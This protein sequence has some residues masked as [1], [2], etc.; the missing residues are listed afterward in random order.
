MKHKTRKIL[1]ILLALVMVLGLV[2]AFGT[3]AWA[4]TVLIGDVN[5]DGTVDKADSMTLSR[6]IANWTGYESKVD[7][8]AADVNR[9]GT[10]DKADSMLLSRYVAGWNV[11]SQIGQTVEIG[12]PEEL[13]V[14]IDEENNK[15]I[16]G[17]CTLVVEVSGGTAP[18]TFKWYRDLSVVAGATTNVCVADRAGYYRCSVRDAND[19][20]AETPYINVRPEKEL[21]VVVGPGYTKITSIDESATLFANADGGTAP[22]EYTWYRFSIGGGSERLYGESGASVVVTEP[23]SYYC[24][25]NDSAY[26]EKSSETV[27]VEADELVFTTQPQDG[28]ID[29]DNSNSKLTLTTKVEGGVKPYTYKWYK[30][31]SSEVLSTDPSYNA[32]KTGSYYCRVRDAVGHG[33]T[34]RYAAVEYSLSILTQPKSGEI[35]SNGKYRLNILA[36]GGKAPYKYRW[37]RN[38][39]LYAETDGIY[40]TSEAG[41]YY[42]KVTDA[43]GYIAQTDTV[44]VT[45]KVVVVPDLEIVTQPKNGTMSQDGTYRPSM[46]VTGGKA[47]YKYTYY[48]NGTAVYSDE[49]YSYKALDKTGN[50]YIVVKDS[51]GR[52]KKTN[53]FEVSPQFT[54]TE[55]PPEYLE[56]PESSDEYISFDFKA[57]GGKAPYKYSY[58][59]PNGEIKETGNGGTSPSVRIL[60]GHAQVGTYVGIVQDA[61]KT[62]RFTY[63]WVY[64]RLKPS[65]SENIVVDPD[66][67]DKDVTVRGYKSGGA[68]RVNCRWYKWDHWDSTWRFFSTGETLTVNAR[69]QPGKYR[70]ELKDAVGTYYSGTFNI[71]ERRHWIYGAKSSHGK[72][73]DI[74]VIYRGGDRTAPIKIKFVVV[75]FSKSDK[76]WYAHRYENTDNK[77]TYTYN[78][79]G[80][81]TF[82]LRNVALVSDKPGRN[83]DTY[84]REDYTIFFTHDGDDKYMEREICFSDVRNFEVENF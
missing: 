28:Y 5:G 66:S 19:N 50:W 64:K 2:P 74:K 27:K 56:I 12:E 79:D 63:T 23:G 59:C 13:T 37:Y 47:P 70:A 57:S 55:Q 6:Y 29:R 17:K 62:T 42:C 33:G 30:T 25:V 78:S 11:E 48:R 76:E 39:V 22:Y 4:A 46:A 36:I 75:R 14:Y 43:D 68:M 35:G 71:Y 7:M 21:S 16:D 49:T 1:S 32:T 3:T 82:I 40:E 20:I 81:T 18:Y 44:T 15:L 9:D 34:S 31:G 84:N 51:E 53:T 60:S 54:I 38:S 52:S 26:E 80:T 65:K 83:P 45:K 69:T 41:K 72:I 61:N 8:A 67:I 10:V 58:I 73:G 77:F 24:K